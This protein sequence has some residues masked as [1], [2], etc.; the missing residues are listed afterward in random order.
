M[1]TPTYIS[2]SRT[3]VLRRQMDIVA[4]NIANMNTTGFKQERVLFNELIKKPA[5]GERVSM[6]Q[7]RATMR[8]FSPGPLTATANPMDVAINGKGYFVVDTVNGPKYT[9]AGRFELSPQRQMVNQSGLPVLDQSGQPISMPEGASN[10]RIDAEGHVF[11][12]QDP[13]NPVGKI[14]LVS[15]QREQFMQAV[16]GGL[17]TTDEKPQPAPAETKLAQGM[18]EDSNVKPILE[19][20]AMIE[21]MRQFQLAQHIAESEHERVRGAISKL[22]RA[23]A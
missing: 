2:L 22:G 21:I 11:T 15:F 19:M 6:V 10:I 7:E 14:N 20:T 12:D 17:F 5:I 3:M 16:G 9:R 18:L 8:D 23:Q 4:N 13:K 1:E